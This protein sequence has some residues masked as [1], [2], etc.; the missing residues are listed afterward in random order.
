[1]TVAAIRHGRPPTPRD[2]FGERAAI[3]R[4]IAVLILV[5]VLAVLLNE[6]GLLNGS[7]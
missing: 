2:P 6:W 3:E 4:F 5:I 7:A 1:M